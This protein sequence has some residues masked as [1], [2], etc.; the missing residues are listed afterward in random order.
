M[1]EKFDKCIICSD[2][3]DKDDTLVCLKC[4]EQAENYDF[5]CDRENEEDENE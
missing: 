5:L 1:T 4:N 3:L 2:I